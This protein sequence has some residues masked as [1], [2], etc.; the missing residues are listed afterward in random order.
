MPLALFCIA[1]PS[2]FLLMLNICCPVQ[3]SGSGLTCLSIAD[4]GL[5]LIADMLVRCSG[6]IMASG[7]C[8]VDMTTDCPSGSGNYGYNNTGGCGN[9]GCS[10]HGEFFLGFQGGL[11][12]L[13][14]Y[15]AQAFSCC[16][17]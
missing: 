2:V 9:V 7:T 6:A 3:F 13:M 8:P 16:L 4:G 15:L 1:A 10:N 17:I 14:S 12:V 11:H 5:S